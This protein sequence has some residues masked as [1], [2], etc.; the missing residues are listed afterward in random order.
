MTFTGDEK[1]VLVLVITVIMSLGADAFA[2]G[3]MSSGASTV[4]CVA[5]VLPDVP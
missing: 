4:I 2:P 1:L 3:V 5:V